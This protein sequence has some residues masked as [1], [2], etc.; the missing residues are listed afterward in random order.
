MAFIAKILDICSRGLCN[1]LTAIVVNGIV[2]VKV[3]AMSNCNITIF[4]LSEINSVCLQ[5]L[6]S[7]LT[8]QYF[9]RAVVKHFLKIKVVFDS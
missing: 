6:K 9:T 1:H 4:L 8:R 2:F 5:T 7:F 3:K